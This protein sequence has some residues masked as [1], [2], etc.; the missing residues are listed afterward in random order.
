MVQRAH[1]NARATRFAATDPVEEPLPVGEEL[2]PSLSV[3]FVLQVERRQRRQCSA[4]CGNAPE[5]ADADGEDDGSVG[6]P[7]AATPRWRLCEDDRLSTGQIDSFDLAVGEESDGASVW[8]P[9]REVGADRAL[10]LAR[11]ER[12]GTAQPQS[13]PTTPH[14][15]QPNPS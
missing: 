9:E 15:S 10:Q 5:Y 11:C 13:S 1:I 8:R 3:L 2:R 14:A 6:S 12:I 7:R 4:R